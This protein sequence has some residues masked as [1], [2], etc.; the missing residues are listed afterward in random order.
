MMSRCWTYR[1]NHGA[2]VVLVALLGASSACATAPESPENAVIWFSMSRT[3]GTDDWQE[4]VCSELMLKVDESGELDGHRYPWFPIE[5]S[6]RGYIDKRRD[7][8]FI[9][10]TEAIVNT[11]FT[12]GGPYRELSVLLHLEDGLWKICGFPGWREAD[13]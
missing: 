9:S 4:R 1:V 3:T 13:S 5:G 7:A 11:E 12:S 2:I 8:T 6:V 10:P